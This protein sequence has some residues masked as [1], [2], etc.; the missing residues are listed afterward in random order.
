[1]EKLIAMPKVIEIVE[2]AFKAHGQG[3][4]QMPAKIYL[5]LA[6]YNGDFRAMPAYVEK[7]EACGIKWVNVHPE[8]KKYAL[9]SVM[10]VIIL[11]DPKT[12]FP[13][14]IMD[15]TALTNLRTG[16]AGAVAAKY[17]ARTDS[18]RIA[19]V[20]CGVQAT[21]QLMA[22]REV[23]SITAVSIFDSREPQANAFIKKMRS[24]VPEIKKHATI[25]EC[26]KD[27]DIIV[28]TTPS[29]KPIVKSQWIAN[30][31]HINAIGADA[32]GKEELDPKILTRAKVVVDDVTQALHS[33]EINVPVA[34]NLFSESQ[35]YADLGEIVTKKKAGRLSRDEIT[36][37]DS[38]GLAILDVA[39]AQY[40]YRRAARVSRRKF[41]KVNLF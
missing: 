7:T 31:A 12:G 17:L 11:S 22:L 34:K 39:L 30:G 14:A 4:T 36:L 10:A 38:T 35:I 24:L 41:Q 13:L 8:N 32:K 1:M 40:A 6:K 9:P 27:V 18:K 37:F 15:G 19:F 3:M 25:A 21:T 26:L 2:N 33:G 28:T 29:R 23:F 5:H 16:A 20:G